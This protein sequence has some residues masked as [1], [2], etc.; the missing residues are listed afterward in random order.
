M[1]DLGL[2]YTFI[3]V[4]IEHTDDG[5]VLSQQR[6]IHACLNDFGFIPANGVATPLDPSQR[7]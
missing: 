1:K 4:D 6:C 5:V 2:A 3:G 7:L